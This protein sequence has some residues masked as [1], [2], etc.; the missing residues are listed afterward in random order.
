[1]ADSSGLSLIRSQPKILRRLGK[2][3]NTGDLVFRM[4]ASLFA[5]TVI[6]IVLLMVVEMT[7]A[8]TV[9]LSKFG[10]GFIVSREWDPVREAF[11]GL[12]FIFGTVVSSL[13]AILIAVPVSLG[14]ALFLT[15]LAP[16][17]L[18]TPL[19]SLVELLAAV[20]SVVYGL[21]G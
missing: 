11:G 2:E 19:A 16:M 8:S 7:Q 14:V 18:R 6:G 17:W 3:A 1:M 9:S 5:A 21:W 4:L 12:P 15:E 20:P 10:F 13:L